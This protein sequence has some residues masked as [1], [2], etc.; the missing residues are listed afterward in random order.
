VSTLVTGPLRRR[1]RRLARVHLRPADGPPG[2]DRG[3]KGRL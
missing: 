2:G 1:P 3:D